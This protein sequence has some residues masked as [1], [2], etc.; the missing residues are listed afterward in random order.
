MASWH[1]AADPLLNMDINALA[2]AVSTSVSV[3]SSAANLA[4]EISAACTVTRKSQP[5]GGSRISTVIIPHDHTWKQDSSESPATPAALQAKQAKPAETITTNQ[6]CNPQPRTLQ[7]CNPQPAA[8]LFLTS[9]AKA[10]KACPGGQSAIYCG[11]QALLRDHGSLVHLGRIAAATGA[12]LICENAFPRVD[13]GAGL[14]HFQRLA[15]FP[16]EAAKELSRFSL[17][18]AIDA[19]LPVAMFGYKLLQKASSQDTTVMVSLPQLVGLVYP[20]P[21]DAIIVDES[22]TSGGAYWDLSKGCP[23]FSHLTLTGGAIGSGPPLAVGAAIACPDRPVINIQADGSAMY[24]LQ[25]LWTQ[26][27]EELQVVTII[28]ANRTYAILKLE[29]A[30]QK[31]PHRGQATTSQALTDIGRPCIDW[32]LLAG[33]M[34]VQRAIKACTVEELAT[35]LNQA[36]LCK[37]PTLIECL[38]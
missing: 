15:Y 18:V 36:L 16:Q 23:R 12:T 17:M 30:R 14:P 8:V 25:A 4:S 28:C 26:V 19:R 21:E 24:A 2:K 10:L 11:G 22:L 3:I 13:R 20:Q 38:L 6:P 5:A 33:G 1:E 7:P 29:L 35:A 34:G 27:R 9:C 31:I 37:G 32:V